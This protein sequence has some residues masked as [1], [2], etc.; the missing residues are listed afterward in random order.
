[1]T[2]GLVSVRDRAV[3]WA[4]RALR[5]LARPV[6]VL[7]IIASALLQLHLSRG[8]SFWA[9]DWTWIE[10]RRADTVNAFLAPYNGHLSLVPVA[11][12]RLMFAV[13]GIGS[14]T[15]YRV[16][17]IVLNLAVALLVFVYA[18]TRVGEWSATLLAALMLFLGP[19][20]QNMMWAFQIPWLIVCGAAIC[21][22]LL[23]ERRTRGADVAVCALTLLM[24]ASTSAG[25]AF[26]IG[27]AVD[28]AGHRRRW[29]DGW[30]V[31]APF[32]LYAIWAV[33]Y[34]P[35]QV[36]L[37]RI[38]VVP[39]NLAQAASASLSV[40]GGISGIT[41]AN[42][43]AQALVYGWPLLVL[44]A[45]LTLWRAR[46][47]RPGARALTL[48]VTFVAFTA[49]V[50]IAHDGLASVL[51]SRYLYV[52]GLIAALGIA[53][54]ARGLRPTGTGQLALGVLALAAIVGN[55]GGLRAF[56]A[57]F[58]QAGQTTDGALT[59]LDLDRATVSPGTEARISLYPAVALTARGY[60]AA[61]RSLG[62]PAYGLAQ[63]PGA[64]A[65]AQSAA[66][67]QLLAD[68][69][70]ALRAG[71]GARPEA[72]APQ[73]DGERSAPG[74]L[75]SSGGAVTRAGGCVRL[76]PL[77]AFPPSA[78]ASLTLRVEPGALSVETTAAPA[79]IAFDRFAAT[80]TTLG[81]VGAHSAA[82]VTIDRDG[83]PAP[84]RLVLSTTAPVR[85]CRQSGATPT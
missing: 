35:S 84:W 36:D 65:N 54:L 60:F 79:S 50:S 83:S 81:E 11:I 22:L 42:G 17:V 28:L 80:P 24:V 48:A 15:P 26:A 75:S 56:G 40:L 71:S 27:I 3:V 76:T 58:R 12:Y 63:L 68:G 52:Y 38:D 37:S 5:R 32:I 59:A 61:E 1:V 31:G 57:Y 18:R 44:A 25:L 72:R 53:E 69:D 78:S 46:R 34:H 29:R 66:D 64:G 10:T 14:Y 85:V 8:S 47:T 13:F 70:V 41:P 67:T 19:G 73:L 20:W 33:D 9:D 7:A 30:I 55:V 16:V 74:V 51:S 45:L 4:P 2:S 77:A 21:A 6:L 43:T 62:T 82:R 23:I 39:Q 49:S